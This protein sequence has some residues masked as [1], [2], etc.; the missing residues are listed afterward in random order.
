MIL[1]ICRSLGLFLFVIVIIFPGFGLQKIKDQDGVQVIENTDKPQ[2]EIPVNF[3]LELTIGESEDPEASLAQAVGLVVDEEGRI[4]IADSKAAKI[5]IYSPEGKFIRSFGQKGQG[6]GELNMPSGISL[7]ADGRLLV[8]DALNRKIVFFSRE[9]EFLEEKSVATKLGL[10][11]LLL[12]RGGNFIGREI[13]VEGNKMYFVIKKFKPDLTELFQ[14]DKIDFPNPLQGKI[15]LLDLMTFYQ[16]DSQGN[17]LYA[18]NDRYEFK[19][20]NPEGK[21][22]RIVRK[23][24]KKVKVTKEDIEEMLAKIPSPQGVNIKDRLIFPEYFPPISYLTV[25][26]ADRVYVRTYEKGQQPNEYWMDIFDN[27]GVFLA[28]C[29]TRA[30]PQFWRGERAYSIEENEDGYQVVRRYLVHW[31][32]Q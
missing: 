15:N 17:I 6:P 1:R 23:K 30:V 26:S 13:T 16:F 25:D 21:L 29:L 3:E 2:I 19:Y 11:N 18:K 32:K 10:V 9:G 4:Y 24:H 22:F 31:P 14:L 28:R 20:Y 27:Q 5:K 7:A 8:E 12:D